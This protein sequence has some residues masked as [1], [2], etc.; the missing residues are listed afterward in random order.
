MTDKDFYQHQSD[1]YCVAE[2]L[3]NFTE[4][5][6]QE[7]YICLLVL[8]SRIDFPCSILQSLGINEFSY[9]GL[10]REFENA[11]LVNGGTVEDMKL[12]WASDERATWDI[13]ARANGRL[14][15]D[16]KIRESL[17]TIDQLF[18]SRN[19]CLDVIRIC[20]NT[21]TF[22]TI[23]GQ[24]SLVYTFD[25]K[26]PDKKDVAINQKYNVDKIEGH[27]YHKVPKKKWFS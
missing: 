5:N 16:K 23:D 11:I 8:R 27:W 19:L 17:V 26:P 14:E 21:I 7:D 6:P 24:Y 3:K 1:F 13:E 22:D 25:N 18:K 12:T 15:L 20:N 10:Y 2:F 4:K 9:I